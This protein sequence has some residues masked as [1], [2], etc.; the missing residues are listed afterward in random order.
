M[1]GMGLCLNTHG[2][3]LSGSIDYGQVAECITVLNNHAGDSE[4][5]MLLGGG[6]EW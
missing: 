2:V 3:H 1:T 4:L 6:L 5:P